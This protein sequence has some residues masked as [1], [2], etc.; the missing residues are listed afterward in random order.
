MD[1]LQQIKYLILLEKT[2]EQSYV[3]YSICYIICIDY[4]YEN[5]NNCYIF[6]TVV[7]IYLQYIRV[8]PKHLPC[9][10]QIV[11]AFCLR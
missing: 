8:S 9:F 4:K 6:N 3:L 1:W 10:V 11:P 2:S 7:H 5:G